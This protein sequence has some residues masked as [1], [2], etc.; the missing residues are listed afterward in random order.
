MAKTEFVIV[1]FGGSNYE[2]RWN[3]DLTGT[4]FRGFHW[5]NFI[6]FHKLNRRHT[7]LFTYVHE[8][9]FLLDIFYDHGSEI[10][11]PDCHSHLSSSKLIRL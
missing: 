4:G 1:Q 7:C 6:S 8:T 9:S 2:F 5:R 3:S 10:S 11:S